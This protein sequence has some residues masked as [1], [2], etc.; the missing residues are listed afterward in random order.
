MKD[1][2]VTCEYC[3]KMVSLTKIKGSGYSCPFCGGELDSSKL[4]E[5][6][7]NELKNEQEKD[8]V[9]LKRSLDKRRNNKISTIS[10]IIAVIAGMIS[11]GYFVL[12][13]GPD[14]KVMIYPVIVTLI[15]A[16]ISRIFMTN[17][18]I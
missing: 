5:Y 11:A 14:L 2:I 9:A 16:V 6:C 1:I 13:P 12:N 17:D 3:N 4:K 7:D 8:K 15:A 10:L 18:D